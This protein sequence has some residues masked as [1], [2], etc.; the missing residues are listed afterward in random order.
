MLFKFLC[1]LCGLIGS[2][3]PIDHHMSTHSLMGNDVV[4]INVEVGDTIMRNLCSD[5]TPVITN[6]T[7]SK[8]LFEASKREAFITIHKQTMVLKPTGN[9][10]HCDFEEPYECYP[11]TYQLTLSAFN[12]NDYRLITQ[13][14]FV[15]T[16]QKPS[17]SDIE[18][19]I[20]SLAFSGSV[21][22]C[23]LLVCCCE[24]KHLCIRRRVAQ[25][26]PSITTESIQPLKSLVAKGAK[27]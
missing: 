15:I 18:T 8:T 21:S 6:T 3:S 27:P 7:C 5:F 13:K 26:F 19:I 22:L 14:E 17:R 24:K 10:L 16:V 20:L 4:Q 25:R 9:N 11:T 23:L 1:T 12:I 2:S